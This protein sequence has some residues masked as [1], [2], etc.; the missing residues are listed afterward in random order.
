MRLTYFL[1]QTNR[2]LAIRPTLAH[3]CEITPLSPGQWEICIAHETDSTI[4]YIRAEFPNSHIIHA[5]TPAAC[6]GQYVI[7][8]GQNTLPA[9]RMTLSATLSHLD[10]NAEVGAV[11]GRFTAGASQP[12][13]P[14]L[15]Q[16]GASAFRKSLLERVGG[17]STL[18]GPAADYD[19]SFRILAAGA[20]IDHREDI[21]F[22]TEPATA[23]GMHEI[24][25]LLGIARRF[26]PEN[27]S[28]IYWHDWAKKYK[29]LAAHSGKKPA[30]HLAP[31]LARFNSVKK[32]FSPPDPVS[33][34][35][36][37]SVF[38]FRRHAAM[39]GDWAR[40]ASVWRVILAD[41]SDNIWAT[42][43][44]C[45]SNGLQMRCLADNDPAFENLSYR[46]L[47]IVPANRAFEGGGIDGVILTTTDPSKIESNF[48]SLR[49]HFHGPI[50]RLCQTPR[51]AT[52]AQAI[53]A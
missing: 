44:A 8:L 21:L 5:P 27:L 40:R 41:L 32:T 6:S 13:L 31:L 14:T 24:A 34:E 47:P 43:N 36:I 46:D 1:T 50:L 19:L 39:I 45:R 33:P 48:K 22:Q 28:Q 10:A 20:R 25:D 9:D 15:V 16:C 2:Q 11:V 26:L 51:P 42:F 12:A 4:E 3:L 38:G 23:P 7:P 53:A 18:R 37:E 17:L 52:H 29:A 30:G 35:V 49:N